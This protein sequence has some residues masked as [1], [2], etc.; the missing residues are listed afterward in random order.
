MPKRKRRNP[1]PVGA[2]FE[3]AYQ[4]HT[5]RLRVVDK[6]GDRWFEV[7]GRTYATPS[8]AAKSITKHDVNG[9]VFWRIA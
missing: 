2:I 8:G 5:Y 4:G 7:G 6:D 9:W 3:R 1:P